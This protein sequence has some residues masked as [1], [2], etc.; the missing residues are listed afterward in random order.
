MDEPGRRLV[1][2]RSTD[3]GDGSRVTLASATA[4]ATMPTRA[5][6]ITAARAN[7]GPSDRR[8]ST[9]GRGAVGA[10][11]GVRV[12]G[13]RAFGVRV[14]SVPALSVRVLP[15]RVLPVPVLPVRV[16][17][18]RAFAVSV[19]P[20][21]FLDVTDLPVPLPVPLAESP[22]AESPLADSP[23]PE[24]DFGSAAFLG[25]GVTHSSASRTAISRNPPRVAAIVFPAALTP[26]G[27]PYSDVVAR[28]RQQVVR[29]H[30]PVGVALFGQE[31]LPVCGEVLVDGVPGDHRVEAGLVPVGLGPQHPAEPLRLLLAGAER[32]R[33]LDGDRR[34]GQVDREVR[35]LGHHQHRDLALPE[36]LEK[37]L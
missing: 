1:W 34:L 25:L 13:V 7:V 22:F 10:A 5:R 37:L 28:A 24:P 21:P 2:I 14:L 29:V 8:C 12:L 9:G 3:A 27:R 32:P 23:L 33:D 11:F 26:G 36:R 4:K 16:F 18:V 19:A 30:D 35:D 20:E 17:A 15:V 31:T 6:A